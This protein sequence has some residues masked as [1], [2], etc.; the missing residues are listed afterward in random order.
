MFK[1]NSGVIQLIPKFIYDFGKTKPPNG[2]D[3]FRPISVVSVLS[4]VWEGVV[5]DPFI[6]PAL[7]EPPVDLLIRD[8]FAFLPSGSTTAT[9]VDLLQKITDML[10][11]HEYV[12]V[13]SI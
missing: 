7:V 10:L 2:P 6:Y 12:V 3:D 11:E 8:Q 4:R 9:L 1:M 5:V 13:F